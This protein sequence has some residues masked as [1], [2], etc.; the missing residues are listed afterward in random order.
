[1]PEDE[2]EDEAQESADLAPITEVAT[3]SDLAPDAAAAE[4]DT[5]K[6]G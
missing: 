3:T 1:L 6:G 2:D 5:E 4:T